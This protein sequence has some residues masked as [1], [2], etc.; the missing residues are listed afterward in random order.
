MNNIISLKEKI[1]QAESESEVLKILDFG[2]KN[3]LTA[4]DQTRQLWKNTARKRIAE[5]KT[6]SI[7]ETAPSE[8]NINTDKKNKKKKLLNN[9]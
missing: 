5:L 7:E 6:A 2:N 4:T 1:K 9:H 3:Y 8:D